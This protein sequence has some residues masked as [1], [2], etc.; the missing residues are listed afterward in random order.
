MKLTLN[1]LLTLALMV[2]VLFAVGLLGG[3]GTVE[4]GLWVLLLVASL[5]VVAWRSRQGASS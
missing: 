5:V 3:I 1:L 4:L 2:V